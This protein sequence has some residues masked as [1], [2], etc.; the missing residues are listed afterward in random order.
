MCLPCL[1][2]LYAEML[3]AVD[4]LQALK[5]RFVNKLCC[6]CACLHVCMYANLRTYT[7]NYAFFFPMHLKT[8]VIEK[9]ASLNPDSWWWIKGDG[10]DVVKGLWESV[11]GEWAGDVDLNDG[12]LQLLYEKLQ[13]QLQWVEGIGLDQRNSTEIITEDLEAVMNDIAVD[14]EFIHGGK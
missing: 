5:S 12:M 10:V 2:V 8:A 14:L 9:V 13:N 3:Q 7:R 6:T 4:S 11:K 1:S